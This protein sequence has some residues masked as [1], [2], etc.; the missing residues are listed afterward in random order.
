MVENAEESG[1]GGEK[2]SGEGEAGNG[3]TSTTEELED[4]HAQI[5]ALS[6]AVDEVKTTLDRVATHHKRRKGRNG[7]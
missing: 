4:L 1:S 2:P 6:E 5:V 7:E 3:E